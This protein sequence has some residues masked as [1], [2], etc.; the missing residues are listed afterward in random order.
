MGQELLT[1]LV[2]QALSE[3]LRWSKFKK[4]LARLTKRKVVRNLCVKE[5]YKQEVV[6]S[7]SLSDPN[8]LRLMKQSGSLVRSSLGT[9]S[10]TFSPLELPKGRRQKSYA[11][12]QSAWQV[13]G[14]GS[15]PRQVPTYPSYHLGPNLRSSQVALK[16]PK[17][18]PNRIS[19]IETPTST[20]F[21]P[22][23]RKPVHTSLSE[24][25]DTRQNYTESSSPKARFL[26]SLR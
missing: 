24:L 17:P 18:R 21:H 10:A 9:C 19:C 1:T 7:S 22:R 11:R 6:A 3:Y 16:L 2:S 14:R 26:V 23:L 5:C 25:D 4:M 15:L 12:G 13:P 8:C 20:P